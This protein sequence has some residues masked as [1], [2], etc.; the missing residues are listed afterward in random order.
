[1]IYG[2]LLIVFGL[3]A[4][5]TL[6]IAKKPDAK[7]LFDKVAPFLGWIGVVAILIGFW[8]LIFFIR[9]LGYL[10]TSTRNTVII[11]FYLAIA[12][13]QL[14]LGFIMAYSLISKYL[15][16][17]NPEAQAK[18]EATLAK[19]MPFQGRLG[20]GAIALGIL[21]LILYIIL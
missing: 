17:K 16:S 19:L 11:V 3:L 4:I 14:A 10:G 7:E 21:Y 6:V 9:N 20:I 15:L 13:V 2:I 5:P 8:D 18:G 12:V 1:M